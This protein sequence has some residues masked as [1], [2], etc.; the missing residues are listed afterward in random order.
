VRLICRRYD[1]T[2]FETIYAYGDSDDDSAMLSLATER[3]F[4]WQQME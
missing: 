3:Y 4:R 1:I 2:T